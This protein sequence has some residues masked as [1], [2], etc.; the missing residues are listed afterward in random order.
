V[1]AGGGHGGGG[2]DFELNL[3]PIIDCF[4]VLITFML[5]SAS[6]L[7]IGILD[8]GIAAAG[9]SAATTQAPPPVTLSVELKHDFTIQVKVSGKENRTQTLP[10]LAEK[11]GGWNYA[12]LT[13]Q[14][15]ELKGRYP[16][17]QAATL[18]A[19]NKVEYKHVVK[20][21]EVVRKA[22]PAVLLG[23]F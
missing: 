13:A 14:L 19:E 15:A 9:A 22:M 23:G 1:S 21:M 12:Q 8:A 11:D 6:F 2:L 16:A 4:T 20:S 5:A 17:V 10:A 7:S 18:S 3:A